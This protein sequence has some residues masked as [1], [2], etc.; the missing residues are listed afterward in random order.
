[1]GFGNLEPGIGV[2]ALRFSSENTETILV[3][4]VT[5][6]I[7]LHGYTRAG[8]RNW[9]LPSNLAR[10]PAEKASEVSTAAEGEELRRCD[11]EP[12]AGRLGILARKQAL[13]QTWV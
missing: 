5:P 4:L 9:T 11:Q 2:W 6:L 12:A 8:C 10:F 1:M 7:L 3:V 13:A